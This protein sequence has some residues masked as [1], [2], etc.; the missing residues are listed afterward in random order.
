MN[1]KRLK[2]INGEIKDGK[3]HLDID[4]KKVATEV[5]KKNI[6]IVKGLFSENQ[7]QGLKKA[8]FEWGKINPP[9]TIDDF[10]GNYHMLRAKV[11]NL[12]Q[13]PHVFHDYNFNDFTLLDDSLRKRLEGVFEPLR[14][15]YNQLTD[16]NIPLGIIENAPY[17]HPQFI[18]YPLGGGF[19]GRHNHNL[20]PQKIGFILSLSKYGVD[21]K[22]GGT[23][24]TIEDDL[25]DI[26]PQLDIGDLCLWPNDIDHWVKQSSLEDKFNWDSI[27]GR[28]VITFAY[29]NPY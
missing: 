13:S 2:L 18:H 5:A 4:P 3:I 15:L 23:C 10:K 27:K 24:F 16:Y 26:E 19:F 1:N 20:L 8:V 21:F 25:I 28:W 22:N 7:L 17:V 29:F 14:I 12:Q 9:V 11:S 6:F